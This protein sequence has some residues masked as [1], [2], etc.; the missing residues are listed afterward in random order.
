MV[1]KNKILK[2]FFKI[3]K[4][5]YLKTENKMTNIKKLLDLSETCVKTLSKRAI[6]ENT[7]FKLLAQAILERE[8]TSNSFEK[9]A[10]RGTKK[11]KNK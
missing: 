2:D 9:T 3:D 4:K 11:N 7:N 1:Y 8:A 10:V 5:S 6:D